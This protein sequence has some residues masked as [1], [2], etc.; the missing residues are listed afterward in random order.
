MKYLLRSVAYRLTRKRIDEEKLDI[1]R[2]QLNAND[3]SYFNLSS[4][5]IVS[6]N[7][8]GKLC[9]FRECPAVRSFDDY[10]VAA[11][12]A[13]F[14]SLARLGISKEH[15]KQKILIK[16]SFSDTE[17]KQF[18]EYI[19]AKK[20]DKGFIKALSKA[21]ITAQKCS[22]SIWEK[23]EY[24]CAFFEKFGLYG[25]SKELS[26]IA[27]YFLWYMR[28][29]ASNYKTLKIARG[30]RYSFFNAVRAVSSRIVAEELGLNHMITDV[31]FCVLEFDN[32][33]TMFGAL[34]NSAEGTRMADTLVVPNG[35]LQKEL[36][37]LNALDIISQ[38][39]DHG[40]NNYNVDIKDGAYT[41]C[42]FDNDNPQ[43]FFPLPFINGALAGCT[44]FVDQSGA[45]LRCCFDKQIASKIQSLNMKV[46][47]K[48][49]KP[50]LNFLQICAVMRRIKKLSKVLGKAQSLNSGFLL[51]PSEFNE[52]TVLCELN[53]GYGLTYLSKALNNELKEQ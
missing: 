29:A 12:K 36:L 13:F 18:K 38:Q 34:S 20:E 11:V 26:D 4:N 39:V 46:L 44:P 43:T 8:D 31:R 22:F 7:Y 35:T 25:I 50:Y 21:D 2:I 47:K 5:P 45:V 49:L 32:G 40:P 52:T 10:F 1:I 3:I 23:Q 17:I 28:S 53:G 42:A 41:V 15:F 30:K 48:R 27:V 16:I 19:D 37:N 51:E 14:K 24:S 6:F 9:Y 33:E